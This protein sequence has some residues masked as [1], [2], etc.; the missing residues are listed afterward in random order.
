MQA[1]ACAAD[2][3]SSGWHVIRTGDS[4]KVNDQCTQ[5]AV[6]ESVDEVLEQSKRQ[7][8]R[9][10]PGLTELQ[11]RRFLTVLCDGRLHHSLNAVAAQAAVVADAFDLKPA[12]IDLA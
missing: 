6:L 9:H 11:C 12:P 8:K 4:K 7:K 5:I 2:R 3:S 1:G 10:H